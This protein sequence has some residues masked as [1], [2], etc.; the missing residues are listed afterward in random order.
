MYT[1]T[2]ALKAHLSYPTNVIVGDNICII[3]SQNI[4]EY[5]RNEGRETVVAS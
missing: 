4:E 1:Y 5:V 2:Y 3:N